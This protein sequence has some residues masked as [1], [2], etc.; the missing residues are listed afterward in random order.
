M[1]NLNEL[2]TEILLEILSYIDYDVDLTALSQTSRRLYNLTSKLI[3]QAILH[4]FN[5]S[6][7]YP[8]KSGALHNATF[9]GNVD[10]VRRLLRLGIPPTWRHRKGHCWEP[11]QTAAT[12]GHANLVRMFI[13]HGVDPNVVKDPERFNLNRNPLLAAIS[14]GHEE[15]VRVLIEH[16]V[17]L[18]Y[19]KEQEMN[20]QPLSEATSRLRYEIV[21]LLLDHG[22]NPRSP[23]F[24]SWRPSSALEVAGGLSLPILRMFVGP[25]IPEDYFSASENYSHDMVIEALRKS[26]LPL[27]RFL[28]DHGA[29]FNYRQP[30][31]CHGLPSQ[32]YLW[33][34]VL[35]HLGRL[36]VKCS[37]DAGY[38]LRKI[39]VDNII[40]E[41]NITA[42]MGLAI[43]AARG[44]NIGLL[45]RLI[46]LD[47]IQ[48]HPMIEP[49]I[50]KDLMTTCMAEAVF[51]GHLEIVRL[52]LNRGADPDDPAYW[53]RTEGVR[54]R[55]IHNAIGK[56]Y[57]KILELLL[58]RGA[59]AFPKGGKTAFE[60]A[61][62]RYAPK[63][64]RQARYDIV[65]LLVNRGL[66]EADQVW[67]QRGFSE[68]QVPERR[69][70]KRAVRWGPKIFRLIQQHFDVKLDVG[71]ANHQLAFEEAVERGD[72]AILKEFLEAGFNPNVPDG[73]LITA[74]ESHRSHDATEQ[75]VDLLLLYG[76]DINLRDTET[77]MPYI[78][79]GI[80]GLKYCSEEVI[81]FLLR[82]GA[83]PFS[84]DRSGE[85]LFIKVAA[86]GQ[87]DT[88]KG[89]LG[90][91]DNEGI[92]F[93]RVKSMVEKAARAA[94]SAAK[95]A[96]TSAYEMKP[97]TYNIRNDAL[98][99]ARETATVEEYLWRW[100][101]HRMYPCQES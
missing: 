75:V 4:I 47:W 28:V 24:L 46:D 93:A 7:I 11:I 95:A 34:D 9:D 73:L 94:G 52:S 76:A 41:R 101:W 65:Q 5:N 78:F 2:P 88:V 27:V 44:G 49:E 77:D 40:T 13:E 58:D 69:T 59:N 90:H 83:D 17:D 98:Y 70:I 84:V 25:D 42:I 29:E 87:M 35:Y 20:V 74:A 54:D 62:T 51:G 43:G 3:D 61:T 14:G 66:V 32:M 57:T 53:N 18:E 79:R 89:V 86:E 56:G 81:R 55:P 36:S 16:G 96:M 45:K 6:D 50:W 92:P 37:E 80:H 15:V 71:N 19:T 63:L 10:C 85:H 67:V 68:P 8:N 30:N 100:Y 26:N 60:K 21:K 97:D 33:G 48:S 39:D 12:R 1:A 72:I 38:L 91:F 22:C 64:T 99:Y 23:D 82:K 31:H